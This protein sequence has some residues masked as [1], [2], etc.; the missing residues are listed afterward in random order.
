MPVAAIALI[1]IALATLTITG[2]ALEHLQQQQRQDWR[3]IPGWKPER[4][5]RLHVID[6]DMEGLDEL[7][8]RT[9]LIGRRQ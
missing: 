3:Y 2:V 6:R 4:L 8:V 9:L 7:A 1:V 5:Q